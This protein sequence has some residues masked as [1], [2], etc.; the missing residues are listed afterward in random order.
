MVVQKF[1]FWNHN[2][3]SRDVGRNAETDLKHSIY[4]FYENMK[5]KIQR[6]EDRSY[7]KLYYYVIKKKFGRGC[8]GQFQQQQIIFNF[9]GT[10]ALK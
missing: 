1:Y 6:G 8:E 7:R 10:V 3:C 4:M 9:V 5:C 2:I